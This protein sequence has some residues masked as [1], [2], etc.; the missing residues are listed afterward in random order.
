MLASLLPTFAAGMVMRLFG[1][2]GSDATVLLTLV[3]TMLGSAAFFA[4]N[5]ADGHSCRTEDRAALRS[6]CLATRAASQRA[7]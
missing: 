4:L 2:P 5:A 1:V 7:S 6:V 3:A